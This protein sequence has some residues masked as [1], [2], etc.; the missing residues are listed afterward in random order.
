MSQFVD[1]TMQVKDLIREVNNFDGTKGTDFEEGIDPSPSYQRDFVASGH[2][3]RS[4]VDAVKSGRLINPIVLRVNPAKPSVKEV[5]D[6]KQR[7]ESIIRHAKSITDKDEKTQ[8]LMKY[9]RVV[10]V[11]EMS[12]EDAYNFFVLCNRNSTKMSSAEMLR[13]YFSNPIYIE[14]S[15][16]KDLYAEYFGKTSRDK[17]VEFLIRVFFWI[18]NKKRLDA[19]QAIQLFRDLLKDSSDLEPEILKKECLSINKIMDDFFSV[20]KKIREE[21]EN[22][23]LKINQMREIILAMALVVEEK[24]SSRDVYLIVQDIAKTIEDDMVFSEQI[25][26]Y[27]NIQLRG[28]GGEMQKYT[29]KFFTSI[30]SNM[31]SENRQFPKQIRDIKMDER[32]CCA[33]C[34]AKNSLE[35]DHIHPYSKG[36]KT[37]IEN[38]Q[39]LCSQCNKE[40]TNKIQQ[41]QTKT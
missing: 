22:R 21:I 30:L 37:S 15:K 1:R 11:G 4:I 8:F 33:L 26:K 13:V 5:L 23:E 27:F 9:I 16:Y 17:D 20:L 7:V 25:N 41:F 29:F 34:G 38:H 40:K 35:S 28:T 18:K 36:G 12:D 6:G 39:I 32:A 19:G 24:V 14:I 10:D 31:G 3:M 2:V